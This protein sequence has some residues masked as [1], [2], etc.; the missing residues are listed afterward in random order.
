MDY[1]TVEIRWTNED[2]SW[3]ANILV[4]AGGAQSWDDLKR[5]V[6]NSTTK[7]KSCCSE[8]G[9]KDSRQVH[10]PEN[11]SWIKL[12]DSQRCNLQVSFSTFQDFLSIARGCRDSFKVLV[13][14]KDTE[15]RGILRATIRNML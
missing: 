9:E 11:F 1:A 5:S 13:G 7:W 4:G 15:P 3:R 10:L 12:Y 2:E 14:V 6:V 8:I